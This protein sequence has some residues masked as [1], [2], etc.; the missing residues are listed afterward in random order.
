MEILSPNQ[1][2]FFKENGYLILRKLLEPEIVKDLK[3]AISKVIDGADAGIRARNTVTRSEN[4]LTLQIQQL[5][6]AQSVIADFIKHPKIGKIASVLM[7]NTPEVRLWHDQII[8]KPARTGGPVVWH[9]DYF[10]WQHTNAPDIVTAWCALSAS[11]EKSGCMY[12][13]PGSHKWGLMKNHFMADETEMEYIFD[14]I[15]K[16]E[17]PH[18]ITKLPLVLEPS[19]VSFHHALLIHGSYSN[20][21]DEDR[22][23]YI[24]HYFPAHLRYLKA[25]D[26]LKQDDINVEDGELI[27]G[28]GFPLVWSAC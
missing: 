5:Y 2:D 23:G 28:N 12:V 25:L 7:N 20:K 13:V 24:M 16:K 3:A 18:Q 1:I 10:Y 11:T 8:Y 14:E 19:D 27:R 21:S 9:Q 4:R 6:R 22:L 15:N 26:T 17:T